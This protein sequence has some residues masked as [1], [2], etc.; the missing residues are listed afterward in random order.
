[1]LIKYL[2]YINKKLLSDRRF[3]PRLNVILSSSGLL[4]GV[5][6]FETDV[7]GLH[8]GPNFKDQAGR[9]LLSFNTY[10]ATNERTIVV[11]LPNSSCQYLRNSSISDIGVFGYIDVV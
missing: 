5:R 6:W 1:M 7:S 9:I 8:I 2:R 4:R 11:I 3:P 10:F